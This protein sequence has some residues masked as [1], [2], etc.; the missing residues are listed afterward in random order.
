VTRSDAQPKH[1]PSPAEIV[2]ATAMIRAGWS[3]ATRR[4]R[5]AEPSCGEYSPTCKLF[6][7]DRKYLP[8]EDE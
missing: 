1:L 3:D 7:C 4:Q 8:L 2:S 6:K 5:N